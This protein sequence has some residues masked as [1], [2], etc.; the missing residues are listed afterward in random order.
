M[1]WLYQG[2]NQCACARTMVLN[3]RRKHFTTNNFS[4]TLCRKILR[5]LQCQQSIL[6]EE[7][8]KLTADDWSSTTNWLTSAATNSSREFTAPHFS[9]WPLTPGERAIRAK[10]VITAMTLITSKAI[11][12]SSGNGPNHICKP[13]NITLN[14]EG[15]SWDIQGITLMLC[16]YYSLHSPWLH[17]IRGIWVI[18]FWLLYVNTI[19]NCL[20]SYLVHIIFTPTCQIPFVAYVADTVWRPIDL[21]TWCCLPARRR[22]QRPVEKMAAG[23]CGR[24][25]TR[26]SSSPW[27][28]SAVPIMQQWETRTRRGR[29]S[30]TEQT[31]P[32]SR[33]VCP[34]I[35]N[36]LKIG[37]CACLEIVRLLK[38]VW[39]A[40]PEIVNLL[41]LVRCACSEIIRLLKIGAVC[42]PWNS[43]PP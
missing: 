13:V 29:R 34:E 33:P 10:F 39:C 22:C 32:G 38:L 36:L 11:C 31:A 7:L 17:M 28:C 24:V 12:T 43:P 1:L 14:P 18:Q 35:V 5:E 20:T 23:R 37:A 25:W 4:A 19:S 42:L 2:P 9:K 27:C 3:V 8:I 15:E 41:K 21:I 40:C 30:Q 16:T 26:P 6:D